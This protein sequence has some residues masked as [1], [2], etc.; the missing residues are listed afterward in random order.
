MPTQDEKIKSTVACLQESIREL[1]II[2]KNAP[3][4]PI[5]DMGVRG[6]L[7]ATEVHLEHLEVLLRDLQPSLF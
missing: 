6:W 7:F 4:T 2:E 5:S 3:Q 1:R